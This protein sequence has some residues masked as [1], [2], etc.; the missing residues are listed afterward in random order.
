MTSDPPPARHLSAPLLLGMLVASPIFVWALL[1]RGYPASTR[2]AGFAFAAV[3]L[4]I[5]LLAGF[6]R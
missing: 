3:M 5:G 6:A 4:S 1:R 2:A